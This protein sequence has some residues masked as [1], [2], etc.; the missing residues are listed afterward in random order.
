MTKFEV[1]VS[2][3]RLRYY[4][5]SCLNNYLEESDFIILYHWPEFKE[6][7]IK[8]FDHQYFD[9]LYEIS[10]VNILI[11]TIVQ[12]RIFWTIITLNV[13]RSNEGSIMVATMLLYFILL[14]LYSLFR[15]FSLYIISIVVL[16]SFFSLFFSFFTFVQPLF[17]FKWHNGI[18]EPKWTQT[19]LSG[20]VLEML[21]L[22]GWGKREISTAFYMLL[23]WPFLR[24]RMFGR[25]PTDK[26]S[27][28]CHQERNF[29]F[30]FNVWA[31]RRE[32]S[33]ASYIRLIT[34]SLYGPFL[35]F[36]L[37]E[38]RIINK[39]SK[40]SQKYGWI[41]SETKF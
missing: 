21:W 23:F 25:P 1:T 7:L 38:K 30:K 24:F 28:I 32:I 36:R 35:R 12:I 37:I 2:A 15:T 34:H 26:F 22:C 31:R 14:L 33:T 16:I 8:Y 18:K 4:F 19:L 13:N 17:L 5:I 3:S 27:E 20:E 40:I 39:S 10:G 29:N 11:W 6:T 9:C 41:S